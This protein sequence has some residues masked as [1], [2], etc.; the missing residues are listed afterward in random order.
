MPHEQQQA[1]PAASEVTRKPKVV[2]QTADVRVV[3]YAPEPG[4]RHPW[5]Y[6]SQVLDRFYCL[7]GLIGVELRSPAQEVLLHPGETCVVPSGIVHRVGNAASGVSRYLLV[8]G[9]GRYDFVTVD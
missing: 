8:Q 6:H 3:E 4:E 5:H 7:E 2:V 1:A 9:I